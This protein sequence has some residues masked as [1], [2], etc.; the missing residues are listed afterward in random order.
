MKRVWAIQY[1]SEYMEM[2]ESGQI[3]RKNQE[4]GSILVNP[5]DSWRVT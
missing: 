3:T 2:N 1:G 5:S 4:N